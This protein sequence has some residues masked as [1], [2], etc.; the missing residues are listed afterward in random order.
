MTTDADAALAGLIAARGT[1]RKG[2]AEVIPGI[3]ILGGISARNTLS[4]KPAVYDQGVSIPWNKAYNPPSVIEL[5]VVLKRPPRSAA[6]LAA[7]DTFAIFTLSIDSFNGRDVTTPAL[8]A[9][10]ALTV[11]GF[12]LDG[13]TV[14]DPLG[15][16]SVR[17]Y[18]QY[19]GGLAK[20]T[21]VD[22]G[23]AAPMWDPGGLEFA[24]GWHIGAG[25]EIRSTRLG[26]YLEYGIQTI[27]PPKLAEGVDRNQYAAGQELVTLPLRLGL[28]LSF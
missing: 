4:D 24:L 12:W 8:G 14:L 10:S 22:F 3:E 13:R 6:S 26:A 25:L 23:T 2:K 9:P 21:S 5:Q 11:T 27:A 18:L 17:P 28:I 15:T 19:G 1:R 20:Y 16:S 7:G